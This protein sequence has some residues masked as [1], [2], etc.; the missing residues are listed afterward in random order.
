MEEV[1]VRKELSEQ[2]ARLLLAVRQ[3]KHGQVQSLIHNQGGNPFFLIECKRNL[4]HVAV[5]EA[6]ILN[7]NIIN[8]II[9]LFVNTDINPNLQVFSVDAQDFVGNT[10]L[11]MLA[12]KHVCKEHR[13]YVIL[14]KI[15]D[16]LKNAGANFN[17]KTKQGKTPLDYACKSCGKTMLL[18]V[19]K[20]PDLTKA[21]RFN[22]SAVAVQLLGKNCSKK[23][24]KY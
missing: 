18:F 1:P 12:S 22:L 2:E 21:E 13:D 14:E 19:S 11:H 4:L 9:G 10:P 6:K 8:L 7:L 17:A 20:H 3:G 15:L 24:I 16:A 5:M 23:F